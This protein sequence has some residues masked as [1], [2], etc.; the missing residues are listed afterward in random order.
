MITSGQEKCVNVEGN[1]K[2]A[3][4]VATAARSGDAEL[5]RLDAMH[6]GSREKLEGLFVK[7]GVVF[8][9]NILLEISPGK[10]LMCESW[11]LELPETLG[12]TCSNS[13]KTCDI[14]PSFCIHF[15]KYSFVKES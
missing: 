13:L 3:V 8:W 2:G 6:C 1:K 12:P 7:H 14:A 10:L 5:I 11:L 4:D 15:C 9:E